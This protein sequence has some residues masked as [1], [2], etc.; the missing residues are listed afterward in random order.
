M[1]PAAW[2]SAGDAKDTGAPSRNI[3]PSSRRYAPVMILIS[4]DLPAPF[5]PTR[6]CTSPGSSSSPTPSSAVTP[7]KR[8]TIPSMRRTGGI[9]VITEAGG[10]TGAPRHRSVRVREV[11]R[12]V[13][14]VEEPVGEENLRRDLLLAE[15]LLDRVEGERPEP[16]IALD[17][18]AELPGND[19][20]ERGA[21][22][23]DGH[24][25]HVLARLPSHGLE[26][27]DG[28]E[29]H[30]IVMRVDGGNPGAQRLRDVLHH[31]LAL[32][33]GEVA[34]LRGEDLHPGMLGDAVAEP[35]RAISGDGR[36]RGAGKLD[37][38][39]LTV[40]RRREPVGGPLSLLDEVRGEKRDVIGA[41]RTGRC[42]VDENDRN[43]RAR[44]C[45]E[46][47][48]ESFELARREEN[49]VDSPRDEVLDVGDL[50]R[51]LSLRVGDD[52]LYPAPRRLIAKAL[53][54]RDA[55]GV[56]RLHLREADGLAGQCARGLRSGGRIA[57]GVP[58]A[59]SR[60]LAT[61]GDGEG[62][63]GEQRKSAEAA[64]VA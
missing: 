19:R 54:L 21:L 3:A 27:L 23:I 63:Q 34:R 40:G 1:T 42:A 17:G 44:G 64:L 11:L 56:V 10:L 20:L 4:V 12:G 52:E 29:R 16:W 9:A 58:A 55:P 14:L 35:L 32:G 46:G 26:R 13:G 6:A 28:A 47:R 37:D 30:L 43:L 50:L 61:R 39:R 2:A 25:D 36:S 53:R 18:G 7:A 49:D 31:A 22:A 48:S 33:A 8:L 60:I 41:G 59:I 51:R 57:G 38:L 45:L 24:D 62:E 15:I 5:S